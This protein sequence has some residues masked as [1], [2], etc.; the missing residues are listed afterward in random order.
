MTTEIALVFIIVT[1]AIATL[2]VLTTIS[3]IRTAI[4]K[5][6]SDLERIDDRTSKIQASCQK[7]VAAAEFYMKN[8]GYEFN[9]PYNINGE[10][11][12]TSNSRILTEMRQEEK[13]KE[14]SFEYTIYEATLQALHDWNDERE[15]EQR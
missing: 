15:K 7:V 9:H 4:E 12:V 13:R 5:M 11:S 3:G 8:K 14:A 6:Q 1:I 10:W 2:T